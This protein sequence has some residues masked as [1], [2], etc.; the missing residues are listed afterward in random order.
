M[1]TNASKNKDCLRHLLKDK[2]GCYSLRELAT[3]L[4]VIAMLTSWVARQFFYKEIPE[5]MFYSFASLIGA[6][7]FGYSIEKKSFIENKNEA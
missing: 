5:F 7:C 3:A 6:G 4:L 2:N 1:N